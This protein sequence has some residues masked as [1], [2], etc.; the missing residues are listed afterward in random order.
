M[1]GQYPYT[2]GG[3]QYNTFLN[4]F[5]QQNPFAQYFMQSLGIQRQP[6]KVMQVK[7]KE[8]ANLIDMAPDS[9]LL[10]MD[11]TD[12]IIWYIKT[13]SVGQKDIT[14]LDISIHED[15][16]KKTMESLEE[17]IARLERMMKKHE[18]DYVD[19]AFEE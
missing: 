7:G 5:N 15:E 11:E 17:R 4:Q 10:V 14:G 8:G 13:D 12:P 6:T 18:P 9:E 3:S 16:E 2:T 19:V 1:Y